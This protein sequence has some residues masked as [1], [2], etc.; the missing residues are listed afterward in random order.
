MLL[1]DSMLAGYR[2]FDYLSIGGYFHLYERL[3][4]CKSLKCMLNCQTHV[5]GGFFLSCLYWHSVGSDCTVSFL[6]IPATF[7]DTVVNHLEV[8]LLPD[9]RQ[10]GIEFE[11]PCV[12]MAVGGRG[13][14][15]RNGRDKDRDQTPLTKEAL[16]AD[17]DEVLQQ[18]S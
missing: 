5:D 16:D 9:G 18:K 3:S 10:T 1:I 14:R 7:Q 13:G 12:S 15:G 6:N 11:I 4:L 8:P 2:V 17:L